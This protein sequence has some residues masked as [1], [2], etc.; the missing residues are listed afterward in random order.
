MA[1]YKENDQVQDE[2]GNLHTLKRLIG[3]GGQGVVWEA[4][5]GNFA[6]KLCRPGGTNRQQLT[7]KLMA[8]R[9]LD[10]GSLPISTPLA[11]LKD[12][13]VGYV[14]HLVR[15]LQPISDLMRY[16][17]KEGLS[18]T[19]WYR[20]TGGLRWRLHV[21]SSVA[22]VLARLHGKGLAY[23]DPS[24]ANLLIPLSSVDEPNV[25]LIDADNLRSF[26]QTGSHFIFT[27]GYGAPE[28]VNGQHG[29][30]TL[31]DAHAFAVIAYKVLTTNHPFVGDVVHDGDPDGEENAFAGRLPWIEHTTDDSN[32]CLRGIQSDKVLSPR[33]KDLFEQTFEEG[34]SDPKK[35]PG[36]GTWAEALMRAADAVIVCS[37]CESGFYFKT[38]ACPWCGT[39]APVK[40]MARFQLWDPNGSPSEG[41]G[42]FVKGSDGKD[43]TTWGVA[44]QDGLPVKL[45]RRHFF[46][47]AVD[48]PNQVLCE[49]VLTRKGAEIR[50]LSTNPLFARSFPSDERHPEKIIPPDKS[51]TLPAD[52]KQP[53]W[54]LQA[55]GVDEL[56][57]SVRF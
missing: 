37:K 23:G 31:S 39:S 1:E 22:E 35:R 15:G 51:I 17:A 27:P 13:V 4:K 12:P 47:D 11:V 3:K 10:L 33:L 8:L 5:E 20:T 57:Q 21:L 56:Q 29:I 50:N 36:M 24:P 48:S 32:R 14:M 41:C 46:N 30:S 2:K 45:R 9:T 26:S 53:I 49:V 7:R 25:F 40:R 38:E 6:I 55:R 19:E 54:Y 18:P 43:K 44:L 28:V 16:S 34:L 52:G 42:A